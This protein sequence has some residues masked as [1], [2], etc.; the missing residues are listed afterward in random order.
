MTEK[1]LFVD[2]EPNVLSAYIRQLRKH[3]HI[4]TALGGEKG[5]EVIDERGPYAVVVSDLKMPGMDGIEFLTHV[6]E[7]ATDTVRVMLTGH[8]DVNTAIAAVNEG[9]IFRF[10]TKPCPPE[11]LTKSLKA[12]VEQYR[13]VTAER[14]LLENTLKGSIKVL[15]ELLALIN[16][17]VFSHASRIRR[18]V[19]H[20]AVQLQVPYLWQFEVAA[21]LSQIGCLTMPPDT[22]QKVHTGK[23]LSD[24]EQ[25]MY[26]AHPKISGKLLA[27]IPRLEAI[28]KIIENQHKP[29]CEFNTTEEPQLRDIATL[30]AQILKVGLE[31][32]RLLTQG[33]HFNIA[34]QM[35]LSKPQEYDPK[36]AA[37]LENVELDRMDL[38]VRSLRVKDLATNMILYEDV[39]TTTG[40]LLALK[41][42]EIT[43]PILER[44]RNFAKG[45]RV[46]EPLQVLAPVVER[47]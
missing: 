12:A 14:Q 26:N 11:I 9:R 30:G 7:R 1:I 39:K 3:F 18:Y 34:I 5:L 13:L 45:G 21:M 19:R 35:L 16:P 31:F 25:E 37:T 15:T 8:A 28:A 20:I 44:L 6:K 40:L 38:K 33:T 29:F 22:I 23:P 10:L 27:H 4:D 46:V 24:K 41:G 32:D 17:L 47:L 42:Q 43:Y 2:D 36:I